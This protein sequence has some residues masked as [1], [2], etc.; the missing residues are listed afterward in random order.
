VDNVSGQ[1]TG[2]MHHNKIVVEQDVFVIC[3]LRKALIELP[4][5]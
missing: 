5:I 3:D 2:A 1:F 4:A